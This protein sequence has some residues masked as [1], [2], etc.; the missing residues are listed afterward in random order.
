[1]SYSVV[2]AAFMPH[3]PIMLPA[4]GGEHCREVAETIDCASQAGRALAAADTVVI[5]GPHG[6]IFNDAFTVW[7]LPELAGDLGRFGHPE[8]SLRLAVD[9]EAGEQLLAA[10]RAAGIPMV[11][12]DSGLAARF[13]LA[14]TIDHGGLVPLWHLWQAGFRGRLVYLNMAALPCEV[15]YRLG[16]VVYRLFTAANTT[17]PV[18]RIAILASGDLSHCLT[19]GS[20]AGY[21]PRAG[22][23]DE[24]VVRALAGGD[25]GLLRAMDGEFVRRAG[26]CGLRPAYFLLGF[27]AGGGFKLQ[28]ISY[29]G[30]FGVGYATAYWLPATARS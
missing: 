20:P 10:A 19:P 1:M 23:F 8:V 22:E 9:C 28:R 7:A 3:P 29:Q 2:A 4:V 6:P 13:R 15:Y 11:P 16:E 18:K 21:F 12:V 25:V 27:L 24:T 17:V 5:I 14:P 26:E 30:P